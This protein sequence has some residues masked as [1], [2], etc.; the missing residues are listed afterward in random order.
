[1]KRLKEEGY[2]VD[3]CLDGKE[4]S[5][6]AEMS[7][8]DCIILD[9][10]LP[11][12]N[13]LELLKSMRLKGIRTPVLI[14][15]AKDAIEDRVTGLDTGADDYLVK[16]FYFDELLARIRALLRRPGE[17]KGTTLSIGDLVLDTVTHCITRS[18]KTLELT[19]KEYAVLEYLLRNKGRILSR[20]QIAE[21]VW[22]YDFDYGSNIVD[23]YVR[24]LRGKIDDSFDKKLIHTIR[25]SGYMLREKEE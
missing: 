19:S 2:S 13:G 20:S 1:M 21:H 10:M 14:L 7:E 4:G 16:P 8:Y 9:W 23:V 3:A 5:Y 25:G 18:G 12:M 6:Y 17:N 15:T 22:G 11:E 24:Y